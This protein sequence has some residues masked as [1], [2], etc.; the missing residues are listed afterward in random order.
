M[1]IKYIMFYCIIYLM[2]VYPLRSNYMT[3][4]NHNILS[5]N[6]KLIIQYSE[7]GFFNSDMIFWKTIVYSEFVLFP[8][9]NIV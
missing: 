6:N 4:I 5:V 1:H 9:Y 8:Y 3:L 7:P 2:T